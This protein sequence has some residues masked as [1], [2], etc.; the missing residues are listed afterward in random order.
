[1]IELTTASGFL[2]CEMQMQKS[3]KTAFH[4]KILT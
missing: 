3:E 1:M 4:A 2:L